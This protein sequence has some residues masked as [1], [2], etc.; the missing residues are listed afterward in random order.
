MLVEERS[1][2]TVSFT[3]ERRECLVALREIVLEI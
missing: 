2:I 1:P 3:G